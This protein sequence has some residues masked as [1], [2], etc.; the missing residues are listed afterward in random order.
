MTFKKAFKFEWN[1]P[2]Q[3]Q[4]VSFCDLVGVGIAPVSKITAVKYANW[5]YDVSRN[6]ALFGKKW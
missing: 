4:M 2:P 3:P 5:I 1:G 6:T